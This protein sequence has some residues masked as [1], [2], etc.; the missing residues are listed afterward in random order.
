MAKE[1]QRHNNIMQVRGRIKSEAKVYIYAIDSPK[2]IKA[3][4]FLANLSGVFMFL[5]ESHNTTNASLQSMQMRP[6]KIR[7]KVSVPV[8][9]SL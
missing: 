5:Y 8:N 3:A 2:Q 1:K 9:K 4:P 6:K 7:K